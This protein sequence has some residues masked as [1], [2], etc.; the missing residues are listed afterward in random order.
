MTSVLRRTRGPVGLVILTSAELLIIV[1]SI[2][3]WP[4]ST[5]RKRTRSPLRL[6]PVRVLDQGPGGEMI[7]GKGRVA[8]SPG[9][10]PGRAVG[11]ARVKERKEGRSR[12]LRTPRTRNRGSPS[13]RGCN[14]VRTCL[15]RLATAKPR[16]REATKARRGAT[17]TGFVGPWGYEVTGLRGFRRC[18]KRA[19]LA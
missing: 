5:T 4:P 13:S 19:R 17:V 18:L 10:V 7:R 16:N 14:T 12:L 11:S 15:A 9:K 6:P 2:M 3:R 8:A 1:R